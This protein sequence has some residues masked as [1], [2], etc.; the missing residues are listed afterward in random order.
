M[1]AETER[2][3]KGSAGGTHDAVGSFAME[4]PQDEHENGEDAC[5]I[6]VSENV[7]A[8]QSA[9]TVVEL[10]VNGTNDL[11]GGKNDIG[12]DRTSKQDVGAVSVVADAMFRNVARR[13]D[14]SDSEGL[15]NG[16]SGDIQKAKKKKRARK[17]KNRKSHQYMRH[18]DG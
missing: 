10:F 12:E 13:D 15:V 2:D 6:V 1:L 18:I 4:A 5:A 9:A 11:R 14:V 17:K 3:A 7:N 16:T 8:V